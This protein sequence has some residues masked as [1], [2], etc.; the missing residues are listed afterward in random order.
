MTLQSPISTDAFA[1]VSRRSFCSR[2]LAHWPRRP[3]RR[4][5][6]GSRP[7]STSSSPQHIDVSPVDGW[8]HDPEGLDHRLYLGGRALP[9]AGRPDR[10]R[11]H[12]SICPA[13][14]A[15]RAGV[16]MMASLSDDDVITFCAAGSAAYGHRSSPTSAAATAAGCTTRSTSIMASRYRRPLS[17]ST[18]ATAGLPASGTPQRTSGARMDRNRGADR[19]PSWTAGFPDR[20]AATRRSSNEHYALGQDSR[21]ERHAGDRSRGRDADRRLPAARG[22]REHASRAAERKRGAL[23]V[24]TLPAGRQVVKNRKGRRSGGPFS[25]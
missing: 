7:A 3:S 1:I 8:Y 14:P 10:S 17:C 18:R 24:R 9:V 21:P 2:S 25:F 20:R 15:T 22:S 4:P 11:R 5:A 16:N 19:Q 12:R 23:S 13:W 6:N